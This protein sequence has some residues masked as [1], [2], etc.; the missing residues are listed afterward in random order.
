MSQAHPISSR[1]V[2]R[3][4]V[5]RSASTGFGYLALAGLAAEQ[6]RKENRVVTL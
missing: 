1:M 6:A 4:T 3:R 2:S 5:L